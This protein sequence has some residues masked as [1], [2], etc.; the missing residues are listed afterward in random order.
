MVGNCFGNPLLPPK[1]HFRMW[2]AVQRCR[3]LPTTTDTL[4]T[5]PRSSP[6]H[7]DATH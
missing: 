7:H 4:A 1:C 5:D 6:D 2:E 3:R